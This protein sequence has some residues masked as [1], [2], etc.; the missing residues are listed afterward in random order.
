MTSS[1]AAERHRAAVRS[2]PPARHVASP[3]PPARPLL[4]ASPL[5]QTNES[6]LTNYCESQPPANSHKRN[7]CF[8]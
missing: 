2:H 7:T 3:G 5:G 8:I 6:H 1:D 4:S